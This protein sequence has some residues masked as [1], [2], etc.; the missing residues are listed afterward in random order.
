MDLSQRKLS[1]TEWIGIEVPISTE[2]ISILKLITEGYNNIQ[3]KRNNTLSLL[4]YLKVGESQA[5]IMHDFIYCQYIKNIVDRLCKLYNFD[6]INIKNPEKE[7]KKSG[8][9][10]YPKYQ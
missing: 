3:Y 9:V 8:F 5:K 4:G 6:N 2:E 10:S 1:K 7:N